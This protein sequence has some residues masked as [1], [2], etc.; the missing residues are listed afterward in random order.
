[1]RKGERIDIGDLARTIQHDIDPEKFGYLIGWQ[2]Q[3]L[4]YSIILGLPPQQ[5][6]AFAS[7]PGFIGTDKMLGVRWAC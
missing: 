1:M 2:D 3:F 7:W 4:Y 5:V 6:G